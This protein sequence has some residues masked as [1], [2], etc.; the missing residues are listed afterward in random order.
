MIAYGRSIGRGPTL[1]HL[2][3]EALDQLREE[4]R[5]G[6]V[7]LAKLELS[8]FRMLSAMAVASL[9]PQLREQ[10]F[11]DEDLLRRFYGA[12]EP[13]SDR[14]PEQDHYEGTE[15]LSYWMEDDGQSRYIA[16][17]AQQMRTSS[18]LELKPRQGLRQASTVVLLKG[19]ASRLTFCRRST[20]SSPDEWECIEELFQAPH[21]L[22][23]FGGSDF[24]DGSCLIAAG[25]E[26]ALLM[27]CKR[28]AAAAGKKN[29]S[30]R[31]TRRHSFGG[32][33]Q[34]RLREEQRSAQRRPQPQSQH[35]QPR[36]AGHA[37]AGA[38]RSPA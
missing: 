27:E 28:E 38:M 32:F 14:E 7:G 30:R 26:G 1:F 36:G 5:R 2:P 17:L 29:P 21:F 11:E 24:K 22:L 8:L 6:D 19:T 16:G 18:L 33:R 13:S 10:L 35:C 12:P 9:E 3:A 4:G 25:S 34:S 15:L 20:G 23:W 31:D 37:A